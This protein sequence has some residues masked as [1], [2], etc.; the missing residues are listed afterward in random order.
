MLALKNAKLDQTEFEDKIK[1]FDEQLETIRYATY[2]SFRV[3][4]ATDNFLEK[5]MPFM[6]QNLISQNFSVLLEGPPK[7]H[8]DEKTGKITL[9]PD[10]SH[11]TDKQKKKFELYESFKANEYEIYKG[12]HS[13]VLN[14]DGDP[15]LKKTGF[16][17]PGYR[18]VLGKKLDEYEIDNEILY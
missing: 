12:F 10:R 1:T 7:N 5:Y 2:D 13:I 18:T 4:K 8:I 11:W 9:A 17:M 6:V 3:L 14:D 15:K 16:K